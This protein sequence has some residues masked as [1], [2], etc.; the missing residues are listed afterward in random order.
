MNLELT[1][2]PIQINSFRA[3]IHTLESPPRKGFLEVCSPTPHG[4]WRLVQAMSAWSVKTRRA[5]FRHNRDASAY[6]HTTTAMNDTN[7]PPSLPHCTWWQDPLTTGCLDAFQ[8]DE[9]RVLSVWNGFPRR[10]RCTRRVPR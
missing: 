5:P 6:G 3:V 9:N 4:A 7:T 10:M 1:P 8:L 2:R